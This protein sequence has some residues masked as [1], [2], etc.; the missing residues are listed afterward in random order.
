MS[1]S[2]PATA[3]PP[4]TK[5][6]WT[7]PAFVVKTAGIAV[8]GAAILALDLTGHAKDS[9]FI[10]MFATPALAFLGIHAAAKSLT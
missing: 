2:V 5:S 9:V 10:Q 1:D 4:A 8:L 6:Q 7:D 3:T